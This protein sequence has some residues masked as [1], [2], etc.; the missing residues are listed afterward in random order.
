MLISIGIY[1]IIYRWEKNPTLSFLGIDIRARQTKIIVKSP[2]NRFSAISPTR[3][4]CFQGSE[5]ACSNS[6]FGSSLP[7]TRNWF[8]A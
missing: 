3:S 7:S 5:E 1:G 2:Y 4:I 8:I 6:S